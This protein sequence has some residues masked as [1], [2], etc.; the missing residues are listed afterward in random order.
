M[1]GQRDFLGRQACRGDRG[2]GFLGSYVTEKLRA[3][4]AVEVFI[5]HI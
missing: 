2:A 1:A 3:R 5:P 4:N